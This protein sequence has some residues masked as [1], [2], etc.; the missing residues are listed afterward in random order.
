MGLVCLPVK[1]RKGRDSLGMV[2]GENEAEFTVGRGVGG[3]GESYFPRVSAL[4][5]AG[6]GLWRLEQELE[7]LARFPPFLF[8]LNKL[9]PCCGNRE[10]AG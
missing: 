3:E 6:Y 2:F 10:V 9:Q 4:G 1:L 7:Q 5:L 8:T